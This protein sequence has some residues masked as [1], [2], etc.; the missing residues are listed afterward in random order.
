[1][2]SGSGDNT[3]RIW[4]CDTG[5]PVHTLKGHT[6]W[7]LAVSW[8]PDDSRI[9]TGSMDNTVRM[10]DSKT[11]KQLGNSMKGHTKWVTGLAWEPYHVQKQGEPRLASASKDATVRVW[12]TNQQTIELVLSGHKGSVSCVRWGGIG[13]IYTGSHDKTVKVWNAKD[14]T[15]AHSLN[16]HAHW[17]N[18]LALST[19]FVI[20][21]A[22][23]D[24]TR[25]IPESE[26]AK[27]SKAKE[28][29]LKELH[30][31]LKDQSD[32]NPMSKLIMS[33]L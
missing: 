20:R 2:V 27:I 26:E 18:H 15:L 17:V 29:F 32:S 23:H 22:Y 25:Q 30:C 28:R 21:T 13:L 4:D 10:W 5:T 7:V 24:H 31:M 19:D 3:A 16:S 9:A 11:G 12:S 1:M 6:S 33:S 14:G 8:S